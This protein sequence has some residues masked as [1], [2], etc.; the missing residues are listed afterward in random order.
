MCRI[1]KPVRSTPIL[2]LRWFG[3]LLI[4]REEAYVKESLRAI[5][6]DLFTDDSSEWASQ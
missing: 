5:E 6:L 4:G 1:F 3:G 2:F